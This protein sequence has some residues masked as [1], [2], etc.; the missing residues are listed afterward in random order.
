VGEGR[1]C[2]GRHP[3]VEEFPDQ[4]KKGWETAKRTAFHEM[5]AFCQDQ[6]RRG[7]PIDAVVCWHSNR[8]S[9]AD[10]QETSWFIWEFRKAGVNLIYTASHGWRD[11][12]KDGDRILFNLE[13]DTTNHRF[14]QDLAQACARGR[15]DAARE[16]RPL[17]VCP[18][19]YRKE[20]EEKVVRGKKRRRPLRLVPGDPAEVEIVRW[21]FRTYA[22]TITSLKK[23]AKELT[24]RGVPGPKKAPAWSPE[25]IKVILP[26]PVYLGL[27]VFG[28]RQFGK[29]FRLEDGRPVPAK[30]ARAVATDRSGWVV[31]DN[32]HEPLIDQATFD[33]V[34][35]R[36]AENRRRTTPHPEQVRVLAGLVVCGNCGRTMVGR[37]LRHASRVDG[38]L[39]CHRR[40]FCGGYNTFGGSFCGYNCVDEGALV[41][42]LLEK[43]ESHFAGPAARARLRAKMEEL[44]REAREDK[45]DLARQLRARLE[46]LDAQVE[47]A[48]GRL[49]TEDESL[50][51]VLRRQLHK[52]QAERERLRAELDQAQSR[53]ADAARAADGAEALI[54]RA[55]ALA[56]R[57]AKTAGPGRPD[58]LAGRAQR[59]GGPGGDALRVP[60]V[61][62]A[63]P[64]PVVA[65]PGPS[66]ARR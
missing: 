44:R 66:Q 47:V 16:G 8:F 42:V 56:G 3:V 31:S 32:R 5:L 6:Q 43:L 7:T 13:Q 23:L 55:L 25:T 10:S 39:V 65:R 22:D 27:P 9:R 29:F 19:A 49:L 11:F 52:M 64:Q 37:D 26:N 21:L 54:D 41:R 17:A 59:D 53:A 63:P 50:R 33:R 62:P 24:R 18:Y 28:R 36:L 15:L 4:A 58:G 38:R 30:T 45:G 14:V 1:L 57:L 60:A 12:R 61:R 46:A 20:Y 2:P 48:A 35:R 34:Q 40:L 51:P